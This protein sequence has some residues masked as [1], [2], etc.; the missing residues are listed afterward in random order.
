MAKQEIDFSLTNPENAAVLGEQAPPEGEES[1]E[2]ESGDLEVVVGAETEPKDKEEKPEVVTLTPEQFEELK[3]RGDSSKALSESIAALG[4]SLNRPVVVQAQPANAPQET[5]EEFYEKNADRMFDP[6]EG[7]QLMAKYTKMVAERDYGPMLRGQAVALAQS[8]WKL[9]K[10]EDAHAKKYS[11]EVE[12]LVAQQNEATKLMPNVFELAWA[13]V[14]KRHA[15]EI[16]T[17]SI[18]AKVDEAVAA[19]LKELGLDKK[20]PAKPVARTTG[21]SSSATGA[22]ERK[23]VVR[24]PDRAALEKV[25]A[26]MRRK[27]V[28]REWA[29]RHFGYLKE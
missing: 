19:K 20:E 26:Y 15:T 29:L 28:D 1:K 9:L 5:P 17:E 8:N 12:D 3:A 11:K 10:N 13:E 23:R 4:T 24:R 2:P 18:N 21:A 16:E 22:G 6:K 7:A 25:K 27:G 14:R